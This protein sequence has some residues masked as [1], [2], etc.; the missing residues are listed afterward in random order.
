[1]VAVHFVVDFYD[2]L[3]CCADD[4]AGVEHHACDGVVVGECVVDGAGSKIPYLNARISKGFNAND[5]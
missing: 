2:I 1:M 3:A 4:A 5:C